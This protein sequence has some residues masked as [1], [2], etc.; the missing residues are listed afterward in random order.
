MNWETVF[1]VLAVAVGAYAALLGALWLYA[2]RHP[3][4]LTATDA[5]RFLPDLLRLLRRLAADRSVPGAVRAALI[6]LVAYLLFPIDLVPDF[7]PVIGYA[8]DVLVVAI[9]LR[10]TVRHAGAAAVERHWPGSA[11]GLAVIHRLAGL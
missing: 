7:L 8:D 10:L 3:Q 11:Q 1:G 6:L 2:R 5:L 9:V 4:T